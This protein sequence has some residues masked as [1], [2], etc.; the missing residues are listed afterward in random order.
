MK[1]GAMSRK[2]RVSYLESLADRLDRK[3]AREKAYLE[4]RAKKGVRTLTD[5]AYEG[6]Q[7]LENELLAL[8]HEL[9]DLDRKRGEEK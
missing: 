5:E 4:R 6:D 7:Q 9:V 1:L 2:E 3:Q 8:L